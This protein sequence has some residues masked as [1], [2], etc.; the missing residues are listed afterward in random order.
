VTPSIS[1]SN[2]LYPHEDVLEM[3]AETVVRLCLL[4]GSKS[5][6]KLVIGLAMHAI[7]SSQER[8]VSPPF[9]SL[10]SELAEERMDRGLKS[11]DAVIHSPSGKRARSGST[12]SLVLTMAKH[13][14]ELSTSHVHAHTRTNRGQYG[15]N[16]QAESDA[17]INW[18]HFYSSRS[19]HIR[20][21]P[22]AY[23]KRHLELACSC[24]IIKVYS[25]PYPK[26]SR[27]RSSLPLRRGAQGRSACGQQEICILPPSQRVTVLY[28]TRHLKICRSWL[29]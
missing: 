26:Y 15:A 9:R 12:K 20:T 18:Q 8:A 3:L 29:N 25:V 28:A 13:E 5:T 1:N 16:D 6:L 14:R 7:N 17:E 24:P 4:T 23:M 27:Q 11:I 19:R 10:T 2:A 22:N 21:M